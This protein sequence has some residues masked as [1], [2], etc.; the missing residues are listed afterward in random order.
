MD[1]N[2]DKRNIYTVDAESYSEYMNENWKKPTDFLSSF[3]KI[4]LVILLLVISYFFYKIVKADLSFSE[5]FNKQELLSTYSLFE[6]NEPSKDIEKEDYVEVLAKNMPKDL[7]EFEKVVLSANRKHDEPVVLKKEELKIEKL[8]AV[9]VAEV[10]LE[11]PPSLVEH[12]VKT[13]EVVLSKVNEFV[14]KVREEIVVAEVE[15]NV[16]EVT[17]SKVVALKEK[18]PSTVLSETYLDRMVAELNSL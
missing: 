12:E 15:S 18:T 14:E 4:L 16:V 10:I 11:E 8:P 3:I 6:S 17:S 13:T 1:L 2:K 5:V 7:E 9:V